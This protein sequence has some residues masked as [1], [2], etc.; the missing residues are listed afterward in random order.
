MMMTGDDKGIHT[1]SIRPNVNV[2]DGME[3]EFAYNDVADGLVI[4]CR[5][6]N[7]EEISYFYDGN[8]VILIR[9]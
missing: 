5:L 3:L 6:G 2:I 4:I 1:F 8:A 7:I 9:V